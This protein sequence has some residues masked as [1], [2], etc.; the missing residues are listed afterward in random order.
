MAA[1]ANSGVHDLG[2]CMSVGKAE[3]EL[4]VR[5]KE[6]NELKHE[7]QNKAL[8]YRGLNAVT[9]LF[10]GFIPFNLYVLSCESDKDFKENL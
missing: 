8:V 6:E 1:R 9:T 2:C 3:K 5:R 10:C 7:A 4:D